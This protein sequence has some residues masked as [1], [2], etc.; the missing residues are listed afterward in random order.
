MP[1]YVVKNL[2]SYQPVIT[3]E[4]TL[5]KALNFKMQGAL[6]YEISN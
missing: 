3:R 4:Q 5:D 2:L 1:Y 6:G